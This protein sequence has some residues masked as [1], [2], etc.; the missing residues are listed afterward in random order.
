M[1][2]AATLQVKGAGSSGIFLKHSDP[3]QLVTPIHGVR[4]WALNGQILVDH[5]RSRIEWRSS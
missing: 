1:T 2:D 5:S 4:T 3:D